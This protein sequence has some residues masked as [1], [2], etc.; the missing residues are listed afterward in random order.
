MAEPIEFDVVKPD[1]KL[2]RNL[3]PYLTYPITKT[4]NFRCAY[5]GV[6][7]ETTASTVPIHRLD[8]VRQTAELAHARAACPLRSQKAAYNSAMYKNEENNDAACCHI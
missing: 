1:D 8:F 4:C 5:C 6:G 2:A 3:L 7:G